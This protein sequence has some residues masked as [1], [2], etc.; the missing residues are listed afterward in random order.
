MFPDHQQS[1]LGLERLY[2]PGIE[3]FVVENTIRIPQWSGQKP[4]VRTYYLWE[5][6]EQST[7]L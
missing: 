5:E 1:Y 4:N 7:Y 6:G 2:D 3:I